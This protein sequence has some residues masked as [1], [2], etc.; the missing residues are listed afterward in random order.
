MKYLSQFKQ[1]AI[2]RKFQDIFRTHS[3][4]RDF[5]DLNHAQKVGLIVDTGTWN[6]EDQRHFREFIDTL[7][8]QQKSLF[9]IEIN[10]QKKAGPSFSHSVDSVFLNRNHINWLEYPE[11]PTRE[12]IQARHL[13]LLLNLDFTHSMTS[14]FICALANSH[15][16]AGI[17]KE[18]F[19]SC[20]ELMINPPQDARMNTLL[21]YFKILFK[22]VGKGTEAREPVLT[23]SA[24]VA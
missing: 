16:R 5:L 17:H 13:D 7:Q 3:F 20:Y 11:E 22:A 2:S 10:F 24:L 21:R 23:E 15:T 8:R 4:P 9:V 14:R 18:G 1:R 19:E 12:K 6:T